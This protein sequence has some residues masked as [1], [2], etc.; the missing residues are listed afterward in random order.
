MSRLVNLRNVSKTYK[1]EMITALD[2]IT[3]DVKKGELIGIL[4][5][6][7]A[8]KTTLVKIISGL[9]MADQ[10]EII[11]DQMIFN[12][13]NRYEIMGKIGVV[14]EGARNLYWSLSV[15]DNLFYF[16][17]L[18]GK[19]KKEI[20]EK[21][22]QLEKFIPT[23]ALLKRMVRSLSLGEKQRVAIMCALLHS[24]SLL[25]LDEPSNGLDI[26]SRSTL[27]SLLSDLRSSLKITTMIAAHD[28][29]FLR[30][31]V[32]RFIIVSNGKIVKEVINDT[33]S[34]EE[35]ESLYLQNI[36]TWK[37]E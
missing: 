1:K 19:A 35:I 21:R 12:K 26:E 37:E 24:P 14:L 9:I 7:G 27:G 11:I 28:V 3:F 15:L 2:G 6:N 16:G 18:K 36:K 13:V 30:R 25:I 20:K 32:D 23:S 22:E 10:G 17:A 34:T 29:D 31:I 33:L 5:P 4:G 8:G